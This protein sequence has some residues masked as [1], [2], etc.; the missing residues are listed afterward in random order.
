MPISNSNM[1]Q[2]ILEKN[3]MDYFSL[4]QYIA[5][6]VSN[7]LLD[8]TEEN[9]TT[10]YSSNKKSIKTLDFFENRISTS[11]KDE[12]DEFIKVQKP[13]LKKD[14]ETYADYYPKN[15]EEF[16]VNLGIKE[17]KINLLDIRLNVASKESAKY[18]CENW[19]TKNVDVYNILLSNLTAKKE[20]E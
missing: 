20:E 11:V 13:N 12:I 9:N 19:E 17:N 8:K 14:F 6:L 10:F 2:F 16:I 5:E 15:E 7:K 4:Q 3:Y 1:S 18:I